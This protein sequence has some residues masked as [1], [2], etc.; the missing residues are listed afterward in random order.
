MTVLAKL[1]A[2]E[3]DTLGYVTYVFECL[4]EDIIKQTKYIMC[5]R[6]PNWEHRTIEIN[7]VGYLNFF[8]IRAGIDKWFNGTQMIPYNYNNN[9]FIKF[10]EKKEPHKFIAD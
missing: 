9:Q 1:V 2:K 10:I 4:D 6:W 7:E 3:S 8:E 5:T